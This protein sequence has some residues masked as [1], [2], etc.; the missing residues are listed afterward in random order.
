MQDAKCKM[1]VESGA[2]AFRRAIVDYVHYGEVRSQ[3]L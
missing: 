1:K 2:V 3:E